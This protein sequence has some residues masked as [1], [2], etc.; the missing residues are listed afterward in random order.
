MSEKPPEDSV[1]GD[2]H[3]HEHPFY[4]YYIFRNQQKEYICRLLEK[5]RHEP[6]TEELK[7]KIWDELQM[8]KHAGRVTIPFKMTSR[9]DPYGKFPEYIEIILDTKV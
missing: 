5:Y 6:V 8:E 2:L 1:L 9:R 7:K 4:G 3:E